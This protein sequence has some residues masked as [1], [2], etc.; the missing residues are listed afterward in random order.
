MPVFQELAKSMIST[1]G[2]TFA[3]VIKIPRKF[4][5]RFGFLQV[6]CTSQHNLCKKYI[7]QGYPTLIWFESGVE[8]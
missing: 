4:T 8:V 3:T 5:F 7:I 6:D 1:D 2:L